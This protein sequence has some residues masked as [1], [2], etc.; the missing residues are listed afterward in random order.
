VL[1]HGGEIMNLELTIKSY[2]LKIIGY[3]CETLEIIAQIME[4][5]REIG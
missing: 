2:K 5:S 1:F 3:V 4:K